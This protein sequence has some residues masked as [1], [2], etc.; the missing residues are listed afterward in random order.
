MS[1]LTD[2]VTRI[3][4]LE[5]LNLI[6]IDRP[7]LSFDTQKKQLIYTFIGRTLENKEY[8]IELRI[9]VTDLYRLE[10]IIVYTPQEKA[11]L[12]III[13]PLSITTFAGDEFSMPVIT[14][15]KDC[16]IIETIEPVTECYE[17]F[18]S[19]SLYLEMLDK[20]KAAK[21]KGCF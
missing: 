6:E 10:R 13:G 21:D 9:S 18:S 8:I 19:S 17:S 11:Q 16:E 1:F 7:V 3:A 4:E 14:N 15:N 2:S 5:T 12:P 20:L